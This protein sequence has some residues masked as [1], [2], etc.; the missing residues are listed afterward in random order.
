[1][2]SINMIQKQISVSGSKGNLKGTEK[3]YDTLQSDKHTDKLSTRN[4]QIKN[5]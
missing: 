4:D 3:T 1:M 2:V 5:I